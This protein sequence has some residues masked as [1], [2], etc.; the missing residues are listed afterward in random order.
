MNIILK[1][2]NLIL[3]ILNKDDYSIKYLNW[4]KDNE[5]N[6]YLETR[7][8]TNTKKDIIEFINNNYFSNNSYLFGIFVDNIALSNHIGN[9]KIGPLNQHHKYGYVSYFIGDKNC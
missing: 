6:K 1:N 2:K 9:I 5:I 7:F 8:K 3:K 4:L